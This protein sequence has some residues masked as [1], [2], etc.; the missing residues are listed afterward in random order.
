MTRLLLATV[1]SLVLLLLAG[2]S[3]TGSHP[4]PEYRPPEGSRVELK[5]AI[6]FPG[7]TARS[8]LQYGKFEKWGAIYEWSPYCSFGLNR[9]RDD[10]PQARRI[11]PDVFEVRNTRVHVD[12]SRGPEDRAPGSGP[13]HGPVRL[14]SLS[15]GSRAGTPSLFIYLTTITLYSDQQPQLDDLTCAYRGS[16]QD[17]NLTMDEIRS[18]L[19]NIAT[20]H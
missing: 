12:I 10:Q 15:G 18:T 13:D 4:A 6:E 9:T 16:R 14:A 17:R 1:S 8:Y 20:I 7:H 19:G 3:S 5:Q 11:E 2:C